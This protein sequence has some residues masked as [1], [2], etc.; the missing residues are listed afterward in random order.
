MMLKIVWLYAKNMNIYGDYGNILALQERAKLRGIK[1][2]IVKYN[3]GDEFPADADIVIGGGGQDSG[4]SQVQDDL[5]KIAP[6]L[7][8]LAKKGT[9]MLMICGLYQLFGDF[10]ETQM[11]AKIQGIGVFQGVKTYGGEQRLIGNI[12]EES[13]EFG[14]IIGYENHSGQ[15]YLSNENQPLARVK[16]GEGNNLVG[17]HEGARYQN[18]IGTYLHGALL[19]KNPAITDFLLAESCQN[20]GEKLPEISAEQHEK[21]AKLERITDLARKNAKKRPR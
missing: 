12:V 18:V 20:Q 6:I 17:D 7:R 11:G 3:P 13:A 5:L 2:E 8:K 14:E 9:P 15:T 19:P 4:Q 16:K 10:F 1:T 21:F